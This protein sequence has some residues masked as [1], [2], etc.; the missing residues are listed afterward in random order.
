MKLSQ[1]T[2]YLRTIV[3]ALFAIGFVYL[4]FSLAYPVNMPFSSPLLAADPLVAVSSLIFNRGSW[5]PLLIPAGILLIGSA[6]LGRVFCGWV[7]PVGLLADLSGKV[8]LKIKWIDQRFGYVQYGLLAAVLI[9]ALITLDVL[10]IMDPFVILQRSLF[11]VF[12]ASGIPVILLLLMAGSLAI[13]RLWCRVCPTGGALGIVSSLSPFG[14]RPDGHCTGCMKCKKICPMGAISKDN[15]WDATACIKCLEC[16]RTCPERAISFSPAKPAPEIS[17]SR[18]SFIA[19]GVF[20]GFFAISKGTAAVVNNDTALIRP[21]GSIIDYRF[22]ATCVRCES[23]AKACL[24]R[25]IKP[26][27]LEMGLACWLTPHLVF[28]LNNCKRCGT[29]GTVCPSGAILKVPSDR[30][31]Q[32]KVGT[33]TIDNSKCIPWQQG[34]KCLICATICPNQAIIGAMSLQPR[35]HG[36]ACVGCGTCELNCPV[37]GKA[38]TVSNAGER[39]MGV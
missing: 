6:M 23:C 10:S 20:L 17:P 34:D 33:A 7:C 37:L 3:Q 30:I 18:R 27:P 9:S 12:S 5:T 26:A 39:R 25:V 13:P 35:V 14:R 15:A 31:K 28:G 16:E 1:Y 36:N 11:Y 24:G 32:I 4:F 21:P 8:S 19:A 38:I 29:C 22:N 2:I